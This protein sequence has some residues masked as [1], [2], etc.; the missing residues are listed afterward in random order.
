[1]ARASLTIEKRDAS[2]KSPVARRLR[3]TD[4]VPG[5]VYHVDGNIPFSADYL[6][7]AAVFRKGATLIDVKVDGADHL[8]VLKEYQVHPVRGDLVHFDLQAV[9]M[10]QTVRTTASLTLVGEAPGVKE[11]GILTQGTQEVLIECTAANIPDTIE[12]DVTGVHVGETRIL[13]DVPLPDGVKVLDDEGTMVIAITVPRGA[14][15]SKNAD[16]STSVESE[17]ESDARESDE[18][19][20]AAKE[21]PAE[22]G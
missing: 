3:K 11:G 15:S 13:K 16:G 1:M 6:E 22:E 5:I 18:A 7:A 19:A 2:G 17:A 21:A 9:S 12:F 8:T 20:A 14:K 10:D 4:R